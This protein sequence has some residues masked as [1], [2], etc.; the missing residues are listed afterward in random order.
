MRSTT[1]GVLQ[2]FGN[3][4]ALTFEG[5]V[6]E[7]TANGTD[8][9]ACRFTRR[10]GVRQVALHGGPRRQAGIPATQRGK[11]V[12]IRKRQRFGGGEVRGRPGLTRFHVWQFSGKRHPLR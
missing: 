2:Q 7:L 6:G 8:E 11:L 5:K 4:A 10:P 9:T 12:G 1:D 3:I